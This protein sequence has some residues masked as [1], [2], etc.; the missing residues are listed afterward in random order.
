M[1]FASWPVPYLI[2]PQHLAV[3][4]LVS[5]CVAVLLAITINAEAQA[6]VATFLGDSRVGAKDRFHFNAFLHLDILGTVCF[7]VGGFG[8]PRTMEVDPSKFR[9]PRLYTVL[10]RLAGPV[11]NLLLANIAASIVY[12]MKVVE[13][14]PRVFMMLI[15]VNATVAVYNLLPLPPLAAGTLIYVLIPQDYQKIKW[16]FLQAGPFIILAVVFIERIT[17]QGI[18]SPYINPLIDAAFKFI[19]G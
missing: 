17:H 8:W 9:Y 6:F 2:D 14:D 12:I 10:V 18:F 15:G 1:S 13:F 7:L 5:F 16:L 11:A 4:A 3:D 19:S